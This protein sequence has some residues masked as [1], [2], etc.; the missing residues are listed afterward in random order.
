MFLKY[1]SCLVISLLKAP[2]ET[3]SC[4]A[5]LFHQ[6]CPAPTSL[7]LPLRIFLSA[8]ATGNQ[9]EFLKY[10]TCSHSFASFHLRLPLWNYHPSPPLANSCSSSLILGIIPSVVLCSNPCSFSLSKVFFL[11]CAHIQNDYPHPESF[12]L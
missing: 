12:P 6:S 2:T 8:Y 5:F 7:A 1:K 3:E 10:Q 4:S 9:L 11:L